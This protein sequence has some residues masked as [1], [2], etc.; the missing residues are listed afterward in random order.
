MHRSTFQQKVGAGNG[1]LTNVMPV[2][3]L[4]R[5]LAVV[6]RPCCGK[7]A[8]PRV[9]NT[10]PLS[11]DAIN[12]QWTGGKLRGSHWLFETGEHWKHSTRARQ[13]AHPHPCT[14][15]THSRRH[16]RTH[17]HAHAHTR[18]PFLLRFYRNKNVAYDPICRT[19]ATLLPAIHTTLTVEAPPN[20][21][22]EPWT[23]DPDTGSM[24]GSRRRGSH[25]PS[26]R[27]ATP[28]LLRRSMTLAAKQAQRAQLQACMHIH[29]H[30]QHT[31]RGASRSDFRETEW[32]LLTGADPE[33]EYGGGALY[34]L[35]RIQN[36][37]IGG[38]LNFRQ[39]RRWITRA[40][41]QE[42]FFKSRCSQRA[43]PVI[44]LN[45]HR[46]NQKRKCPWHWIHS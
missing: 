37:S 28:D 44:I 26:T 17:T 11:G 25:V 24:S 10:I 30:G 38:S 5:K 13:P 40:K 14:K 1:C 19:Y 43:S 9:R 32:S 22:Q 31:H 16:A 2:V 7:A 33:P 8:C 46:K 34:W 12:K 35:G 36:L 20:P 39:W 3:S 21:K 6:W 27:F 18:T 41:Q 45:L 23:M 42:I 15:H 29:S 4:F